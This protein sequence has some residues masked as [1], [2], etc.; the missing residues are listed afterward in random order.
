M[1]RDGGGMAG[2]PR[3]SRQ[4]QA[5]AAPDAVVGTGGDLLAP[6]YEQV[7][8]G[9]QDLS[10]PV[11]RTRDRRVNQVWRSDVTYI[12]MAM[13]RLHVGG[14]HSRKEL[15]GTQPQCRGEAP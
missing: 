4:L 5:G 11:A 6:E 10:L 12:P 1:V 7:G 8:R 15:N 9:A 3:P 14:P 2:D 13:L